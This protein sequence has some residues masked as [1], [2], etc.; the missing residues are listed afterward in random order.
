M[1]KTNYLALYMF[2]YGI[3]EIIFSYLLFSMKQHGIQLYADIVWYI[4]MT[5]YLAEFCYQGHV[6]LCSQNRQ[7]VL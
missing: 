1:E 4:V 3:L 5:I 6:G 2:I 7:M